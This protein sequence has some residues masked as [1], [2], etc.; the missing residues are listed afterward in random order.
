M[1]NMDAFK[2]L[3]TRAPDLELMNLEQLHET[4]FWSGAAA[5]W[6]RQ[7]IDMAKGYEGLQSQ[8]SAWIKEGQTVGEME[9]RGQE[10]LGAMAKKEDQVLAPSKKHGGG[11]VPSVEPPKWQRLG[12]KSGKAMKLAEFLAAHPEEVKEVIKE[13][14]EEDDLPSKGAVKSKV[15]AKKAEEAMQQRRTEKKESPLLSEHLR[16]CISMQSEINI[17]LSAIAENIDQ[18]DAEDMKQIAKLIRRAA[19]L[20]MKADRKEKQEWQKFLTS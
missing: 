5:K 13:A 4:V 9:L 15:R 16:W 11:R 17:K 14:K 3:M 20:L 6:A 7:K 12:F 10:R 19:E 18:V 8:V 1:N 2:E